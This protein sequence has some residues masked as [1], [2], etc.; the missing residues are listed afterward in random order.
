M[1]DNELH[2]A[3]IEIRILTAIITKQARHEI[4]ERFKA[5]GSSLSALQYR[6]LLLLQHAPY[7]IKDLSQQC[8][9]EPATLVPVI[10]ALERQGLVQRGHDPHDRRRTPLALTE[11]GMTQLARIPFADDQ[12]MIAGYLSG[13]NEDERHTFVAHLR[14]LTTHLLG[15]DHVARQITASLQRHMDF[16][17]SRQRFHNSPPPAK[18]EA[19]S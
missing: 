4:E 16:E 5:H 8:M 18:E 10:D 17:T 7:T 14:G 15:D 3:A 13:L 12:D 6:V 2:I 9:V 19:S 11:H 1:S